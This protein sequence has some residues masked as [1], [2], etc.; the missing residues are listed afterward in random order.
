V[1]GDVHFGA[2]RVQSSSGGEYITEIRSLAEL[3]N[4]CGYRDFETSGLDTCKHIEGVL[5]ALRRKGKRA[6]NAAAK[7][8]SP[9]VEVYPSGRGE[10]GVRVLWPEDAGPALRE[11]LGPMIAALRTDAPA[12]LDGLRAVAEDTPGCVRVS[13]YLDGWLPEK[14]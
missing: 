11:R 4:S 13:R 3:E 1:T 5:H 2:F 10:A 9:G 7:R 8:G 12:A 14:L 6:F